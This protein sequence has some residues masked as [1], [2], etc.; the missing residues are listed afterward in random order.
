MKSVLLIGIGGV[1]NYGCEAIVRGTEMLLRSKWPDLRIVYASP[2]PEDDRKRLQG[3]N[4]EIIQRKYSRYSPGNITRKL[5]SYAGVT[6]S[7][8]TDSI[9]LLKGIDAVLSIGGDIYTLSSSGRFNGSLAKFG[10]LAQKS[11]IPYILWCASVGPFIRNAKAERF[12]RKHLLNI[13]LISAREKDTIEY[14]RNIGVVWN[15]MSAADPAYL[16]APQIVKNNKRN[17]SNPTIAV[18]LSPLSLR[19]NG[20]SLPDAI[21]NQAR[22]IEN[23]VNAYNANVLLIPHVVCDVWEGDDDRRYLRHIWD[24]VDH[25]SRSRVQLVDSDPGFIGVKHLLV[26]CDLVIAARMHCAINAMAAHVPTLLLAYSQKAQGMSEYIYGHRDWVIPLRDFASD[27]CLLT[28][29]RMLRQEQD[30]QDQLSQRV[31]ELQ[32]NSTHLASRLEA[33]VIGKNIS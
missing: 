12:F 11:G 10:D 29:S 24:T 15:V 6:W 16:V 30:I 1:Y 13:S 33:T 20:I 25:A 19:H 26:Q 2:R 32:Q 17:S 7:R 23:I 18:N 28:I 31:S 22:A 5:I 21:Q 27:N 8:R 14:L 9:N 3:T 4:I